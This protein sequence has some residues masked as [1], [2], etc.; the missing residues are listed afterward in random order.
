MEMSGRTGAI[1][2]RALAGCLLAGCAQHATG[3][4]PTTAPPSARASTEP[5]TPAQA[6]PDPLSGVNALVA[7]ATS[8]QSVDA[9]G[10]VNAP[11]AD[12]AAVIWVGAPYP[13]AE[14]CA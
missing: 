6:P 2:G 11:P 3:A 5:P 7:T 8:L 12:D 14:G 4:E 1:V 13:V 10:A 9:D